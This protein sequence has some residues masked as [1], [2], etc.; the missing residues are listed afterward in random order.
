MTEPDHSEGWIFGHGVCREDEAV[1]RRADRGDPKTVRAGDN[2]GLAV[3]GR[4]VAGDI[5]ME[6]SLW[7]SGVGPYAGVE[8]AAGRAHPTDEAGCGTQSGQVNHAG[9]HLKK[10]GPAR[11]LAPGDGCVLCQNATNRRQACHNVCPQRSGQ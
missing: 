9:H 4:V 6:E 8:A 11:G 3:G 1:L 5:P 10:R 7:Q 2:D